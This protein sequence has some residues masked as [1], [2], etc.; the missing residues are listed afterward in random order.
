MFFIANSDNFDDVCKTYLKETYGITSYTD[1]VFIKGEHI[2]QA[3]SFLKWL[4]DNPSEKPK[5]KEELLNERL[6]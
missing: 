2:G 3:Q 5:S 6:Y 4:E 1:E